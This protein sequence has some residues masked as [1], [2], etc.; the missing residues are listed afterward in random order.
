MISTVQIFWIVAVLL[1]SST[2]AQQQ[3]SDSLIILPGAEEIKLGKFKGE[4]ELFYYV[5]DKFP[6]FNT[7]RTLHQKLVE[8]GWVQLKE[9][10]M[11]PGLHL[12]SNPGLPD[13]ASQEQ[14]I[15]FG[16]SAGINPKTSDVYTYRW[17]T[18]Y[19]NNK[20]EI[21]IY[22]FTYTDKYDRNY[23][24]YPYLHNVIPKAKRL[25]VHAVY[26][27][28]DLADKLHNSGKEFNNTQNK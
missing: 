8:K 20:R 27:P 2:S 15:L 3:Y 21:V 13:R 18:Q 19:E 12:S 17:S 4:D 7:I 6:A 5:D 1:S 10:F 22:A 25:R 24:E 28:A 11:N 23:H 9:D 16:W 14:K 26:F